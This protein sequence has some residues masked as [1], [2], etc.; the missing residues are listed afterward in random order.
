M[1]FNKKVGLIFLLP[2]TFISCNKSSFNTSDS[3]FQHLY[4]DLIGP[5]ND[6][7][8]TIDTEV[9]SYTFVLS[10]NK[11]VKSFGYQSDPSL[12]STAYVIEIVRSSD[13]SVVYSGAHQF[14]SAAISYV[15]P[16]T[17]IN[18]QSGVSYT[19]NRIQTNWV[20]YIT[21]TIG[22]VIKTE[23]SDYPLSNG[24]LTITGTDFHDLGDA[25]NGLTNFALPRID[26]V[27][28]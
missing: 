7:E 22:H 28:Q 15:T 9:H 12:S 2:L 18:L 1:H 4:N 27:L 23:S 25:P 19:L 14:S 8:I 16:T 17:S 3:D 10:E 24:V 26:M 6:E 11:T 21:E 20:Q 13:S 5:G